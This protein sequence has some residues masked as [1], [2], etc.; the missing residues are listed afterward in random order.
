MY[1]FL[2]RDE[3]ICK[4]EIILKKIID[5]KH[6]EELLDI[7]MDIVKKLQEA[8]PKPYYGFAQLSLGFHEIISFRAVKNKFA[9]RGEKATKTIVAELQKEILFLPQYFSERLTEDDIDNL[10]S[11][12]DKVYLYFEGQNEKTK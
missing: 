6:F 4:S 9:K 11:C 12:D 1:L 3:N 5:N 8:K 7:T 10:N 2:H